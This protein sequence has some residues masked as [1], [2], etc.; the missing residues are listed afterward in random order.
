MGW[1]GAQGFRVQNAHSLEVTAL[2]AF[3][4]WPGPEYGAGRIHSTVLGMPGVCPEEPG[5]DRR[6]RKS[7]GH[8]SL[9]LLSSAHC[10]RQPCCSPPGL[11]DSWL[12]LG[13]STHLSSV[14]LSTLGVS[15]PL[16]E[17]QGAETHVRQEQ[18]G[19]SRGDTMYGCAAGGREAKGHCHGAGN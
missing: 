13:A 10:E 16:S 5:G 15:L 12:C 3:R 8:F 14:N 9:L 2:R 17:E 4:S 19:P 11:G 18:W 1:C 7:R 6:D